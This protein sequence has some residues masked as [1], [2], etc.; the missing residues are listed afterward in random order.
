MFGILAW[1]IG[2]FSG[3]GWDD[4]V[5]IYQYWPILYYG[6]PGADT[7]YDLV[8]EV[9]GWTPSSAGDVNGDGWNDYFCGETRTWWG[10]VDVF[11]G[12]PEGDSVSD[13][14]I[15]DGDFDP[16]PSHSI[17]TVGSQV[18]PAGD[19]NGDGYSDLLIANENFECC[20]WEFGS[21]YVVAGGPDIVAGVEDEESQPLPTEFVMRQN[22]PNPFN[23]TTTVSFDLPQCQRVAL[24]VRNVIGRGVRTILDTELSPG[25]H[26]VTWDGTDGDGREVAS[27]LYIITL[28]GKSG[29]L[30]I[31]ALLLK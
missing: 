2:D 20:D 17:E 9:G 13:Y 25:T 27:G 7:L 16:Y 30:S 14:T 6:G 5:I 22:Y 18:A 12:G 1:N 4:L 3:D 24:R 31:K 15:Y 29:A 8:P 23:T 19:F 21:V 26:S 28:T 11:L 10:A